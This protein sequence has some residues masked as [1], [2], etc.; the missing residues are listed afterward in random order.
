MCQCNE[1]EIKKEE[2]IMLADYLEEFFSH[3]PSSNTPGEVDK[4]TNELCSKHLVNVSEVK[5]ILSERG[6]RKWVN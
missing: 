5:K 1:E 2:I 3:N 4:L 6:I